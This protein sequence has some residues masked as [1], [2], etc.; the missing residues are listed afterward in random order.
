MRI[1]AVSLAGSFSRWLV[2]AGVINRLP[3]A[4]SNTIQT[5]THSTRSPSQRYLHIFAFLSLR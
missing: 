4:R 1:L 3:A 2:V 5:Q